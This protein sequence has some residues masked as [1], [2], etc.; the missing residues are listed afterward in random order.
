VPIGAHGG[1]YTQ[2]QHI[3]RNV[4]FVD[5]RVCLRSKNSVAGATKRKP[6]EVSSLRLKRTLHV[7]CALCTRNA[8]KQQS[9]PGDTLPARVILLVPR[10]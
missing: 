4:P 10:V 3:G 8:D 2:E 7:T 6:V 9:L 5:T 1:R